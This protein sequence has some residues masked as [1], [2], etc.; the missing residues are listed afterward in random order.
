MPIP[1]RAAGRVRVGNSLV[2]AN[3]SAQ[4]VD[5]IRLEQRAVDRMARDADS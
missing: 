5:S 4:V 2:R 3:Y 1:F